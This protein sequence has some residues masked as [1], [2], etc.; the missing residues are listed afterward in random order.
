MI[1]KGYTCYTAPIYILVKLGLLM[2]YE[3]ENM[4]FT[5]RMS[6]N[7]ITFK[8]WNFCIHSASFPTGTGTPSPGLKRPGRVANQS[9]PSSAEVKNEWSNTTLPP[10]C[11]HSVHV[12]IIFIFAFCGFHGNHKNIICSWDM[13]LSLSWY[14][15]MLQAKT[16]PTWEGSR[17]FETSLKSHQII[18]RQ[19]PW[20]SNLRNYI[21][22]QFI[23][24]YVY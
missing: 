4:K 2:S 7:N 3:K 21:P 24:K 17:L 5:R 11:L 6:Y 1:S 20:Y 22:T 18:W 8:M 23:C 10:T 16:L 12:D 9:P 14:V 19:I 13:T 15:F